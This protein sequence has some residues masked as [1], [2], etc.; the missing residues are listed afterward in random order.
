MFSKHLAA[1]RDLTRPPDWKKSCAHAAD[2]RQAK[3]NGAHRYMVQKSRQLVL[4]F[5][6]RRNSSCGIFGIFSALPC[7]TFSSVSL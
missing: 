1:S 6:K 3:S 4:D 5:L 7:S 2:D